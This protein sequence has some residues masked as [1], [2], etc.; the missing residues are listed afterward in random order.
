MANNLKSQTGPQHTEL[1]KSSFLYEIF[2]DMKINSIIYFGGPVNLQHCFVLHDESYL[3]KD[4]MKISE[5]ISLTSNTKIIEDI[6][7]NLKKL[8]NNL[9]K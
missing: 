7:N 3:T 8:I 9:S 1:N 6:K 2:E 4:T 5:E